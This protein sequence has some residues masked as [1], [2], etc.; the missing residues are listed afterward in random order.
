MH[1]RG[2]NNICVCKKIIFIIGDDEFVNKLFII[3]N[4]NINCIEYIIWKS[5]GL[6]LLTF[7][8]S[9]KQLKKIILNSN[10]LLFRILYL[11]FSK[12]FKF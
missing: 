11:L 4:L 3:D 8:F 9:I 2:L 5:K 7:I 10:E 6:N 12:C 1:Q